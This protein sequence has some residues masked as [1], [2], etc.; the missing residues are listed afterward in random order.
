MTDETKEKDCEHLEM[1]QSVPRGLLRHIIPR[2]LKSQNLTGTQIMQELHSLTDGEWNPSPGTI[3]PLLSSLEEEGTIQTVKTE[4]RMRTYSLTD[5][6]RKQ[7]TLFIKH[8][9]QA[10]GHKTRL[11]PR[12]WERLLEPQERVRF[13]MHG[14]EYSIEALE[15]VEDSLNTKDRQRLLNQLEEMKNRISTLMNR[16]KPGGT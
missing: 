12:L 6:G 3:Y 14:M 9:K 11:G 8:R 10:V 15:S 13:H 16:L 7:M 5:L 2:L 4:G 1:P